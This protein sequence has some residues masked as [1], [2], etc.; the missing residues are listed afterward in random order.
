MLGLLCCP[1][2][3]PR[4][5]STPAHWLYTCGGG[6]TAGGGDSDVVQVIELTEDEEHD[7]IDVETFA[8]EVLLV[9]AVKPDPDAPPPAT[10]NTTST[11]CLVTVFKGSASKALGDCSASGQTSVCGDIKRKFDAWQASNQGAPSHDNPIHV[12]YVW[13][14]SRLV[15]VST[16]AQVLK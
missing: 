12:T 2:A 8:I 14:G 10:S 7:V 3:C 15:R 1:G 6:A 5:Q 9:S 16:R 4:L 11:G 13:R